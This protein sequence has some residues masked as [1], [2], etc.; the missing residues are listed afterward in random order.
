MVVLSTIESIRNHRKR[1]LMLLSMSDLHFMRSDLQNTRT[2]YAS[3]MN[4]LLLSEKEKEVVHIKLHVIDG[5]ILNV[6]EAI[7][8]IANNCL[9]LNREVELLIEN[10]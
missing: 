8:E 3:Q 2:S 7:M 1:K 10:K 5:A 4:S 9:Y 6:D